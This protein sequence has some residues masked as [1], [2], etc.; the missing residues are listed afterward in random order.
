MTALERQDLADKRQSNLE[1]MKELHRSAAE[2]GRK[3][4]K[5]AW[6]K[7]E[8]EDV[9]LTNELRKA[10]LEA[11]QAA[12]DAE[13][14]YKAVHDAP[15]SEKDDVKRYEEVLT[16]YLRFDASSLNQEERALLSRNSVQTRGTGNQTT[17]TTAG[18]FTIPEGFSNRLHIEKALWGAMFNVAEIITTDSGEA[19][20]WPKVDDTSES[21]ELLTEASAANVGDMAFTAMTLNAYMYHSKI[22]K[23]SEQLLQDSAFDL[24]RDLINIFARRLGVAENSAF[25]SADGSSKPN[26]FLT[27]A[28]SATTAASTST[29]TRAEINT[30]QHA[31]NPVYRIG[32]K[33]GFMCNDSTLSAIKA[34]SFAV[35]ASDN[36]P[37]WMP[38]SRP[39]EPD[40]IN[41][42]PVF[43]NQQMANLTNDST[44]LAFG[45][46]S[47]YKIRVVRG[48]QQIRRLN[49]LYAGN[50]LV[51]FMAYERVDGDL[52]AT[53]AIKYIT[54][55]ST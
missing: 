49:E 47:Q 32:P 42:Y 19:I 2:A 51:G 54:Q 37:L 1:K 9:R 43:I 12:S 18:G 22:V 5:E 7:Y 20:P 30:L 44:S 28:A 39:G 3:V 38:A 14:A 8:D 40:K 35:A 23:I 48:S 45:D 27:A 26:G 10:D 29:I 24:G 46:F 34:T 53:G 55:A 50:L 13:V 52:L 41:G 6:K 21:G 15:K 25:T 17:T 4:D 31:V 11:K 33:V 36:G 16:K